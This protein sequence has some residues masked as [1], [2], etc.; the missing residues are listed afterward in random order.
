MLCL[1]S[2]RHFKS[3]ALSFLATVFV[4]FCMIQRSS[5]KLGLV[6]FFT[7]WPIL[8]GMHLFTLLRE[9]RRRRHVGADEKSVD[10]TC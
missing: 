10:Q 8:L 5:N 6:V 3:A 4:L 9:R 2:Y 7:A 1:I